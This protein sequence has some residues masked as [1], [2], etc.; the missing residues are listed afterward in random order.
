MVALIML[1]VAADIYPPRPID[2]KTSYA[3]DIILQ[4]P[5]PDT[6]YV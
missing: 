6:N 5:S 3:L 1:S 2:L 4:K